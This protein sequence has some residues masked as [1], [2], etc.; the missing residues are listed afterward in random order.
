MSS[1]VL[2][3][4]TLSWKAEIIDPSTIEGVNRF[5]ELK[6]DGS[7]QTVSDTL[8]NQVAEL[9][10]IRN[11]V[12]KQDPAGLAKAIG[13]ILVGK[14]WDT[15]GCWVVYHWIGSAVR[16]L[17]EDEFVEVRTNRNKNRIS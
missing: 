10:I 11:P 12:L 14:D 4:D 2:Y 17:P 6:L 16:L 9:A 7:I 1:S 3:A 13:E 8:E 5:S 15:Y